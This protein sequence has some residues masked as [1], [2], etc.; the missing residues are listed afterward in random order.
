[1][2]DGERL[3]ESFLRR[4]LATIERL[5]GTDR[6]DLTL[7][8]VAV[9]LRVYLSDGPHT[10]RGMAKTIGVGKPAISRSIDRLEGFGLVCRTPDP[11][12][13]RS[14]LVGR[15]GLGLAFLEGLSDEVEGLEVGSGD[16][17][18]PRKMFVIS[19]G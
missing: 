2:S 1:M 17:V 5:V 13:A 11:R 19:R 3:D 12:D 7:C 18:H 16:G 9:F 14:I 6:K 15:T 4:M 8:Q 10:V